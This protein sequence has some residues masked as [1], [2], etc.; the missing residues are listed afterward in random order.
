M[1][2]DDMAKAAATITAAK[3]NFLT[4]RSHFMLDSSSL[5]AAAESAI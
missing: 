4:M 1:G 2:V 3:T 5:H